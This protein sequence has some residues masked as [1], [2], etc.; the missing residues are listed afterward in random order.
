MEQ[1]SGNIH[2]RWAQVNS[3]FNICIEDEGVGIV[4]PENLFVPFYST[5]RQGGGIGL[6]L[7]RQIAEQHDGD[8]SLE[9][10]VSGRGCVATVSLPLARLISESPGSN[11]MRNGGKAIVCGP[12]RQTA[13]K[14][15]NAILEQIGQ[16]NDDCR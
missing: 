5:K 2:V 13:L 15:E 6:L 16:N 7:C 4:N 8:L 1:M 12:E 3:Q 10:R 9:N 14:R 11:E